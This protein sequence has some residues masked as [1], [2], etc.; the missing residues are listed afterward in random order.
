MNYATV[1]AIAC[2]CAGIKPTLP[3]A[4]PGLTN[5]PFKPCPGNANGRTQIERGPWY[6]YQYTASEWLTI[7]CYLEY[8]KAERDSFDCPGHPEAVELCYALVN[9][10]DVLEVL[11]DDVVA[12]IEEKALCQMA[13]DQR[14][15]EYDR[16][17]D[18]YNDRMAAL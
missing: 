6:E 16:G 1:N 14:E 5:T 8:E 17:E 7:D 15:D 9:G 13:E 3:S 12:H 2:Q 11:S 4:W 10:V 18:R